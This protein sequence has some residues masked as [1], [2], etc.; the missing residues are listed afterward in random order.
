MSFVVDVSCGVGIDVKVEVGVQ[1]GVEVEVQLEL[2]VAAGIESSMSGKTRPTRGWPR[3]AGVTNI[4][5]TSV[6]D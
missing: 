6:A 1:V 5:G 2:N 4:R 3:P